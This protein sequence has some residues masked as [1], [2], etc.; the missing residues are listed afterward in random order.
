MFSYSGHQQLQ[1]RRPKWSH[2]T[3]V[4]GTSLNMIVPLDNLTTGPYDLTYTN[5]MEKVSHQMMNKFLNPQM[6]N[7]PHLDPKQ[8]V[9]AK[10]NSHNDMHLQ[11]KQQL[12][13]Q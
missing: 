8:I 2:Y 3:E 11:L 7:Q 4:T 12:Q 10:K 13:C 1:E 9:P 5:S 6:K